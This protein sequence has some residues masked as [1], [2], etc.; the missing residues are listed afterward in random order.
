MAQAPR[1]E[2]QKSTCEVHPEAV[3]Q[4]TLVPWAKREVA[5]VHLWD[6]MGILWGFHGNL[7][8]LN[9][10]RDFMGILFGDLGFNGELH[11]GDLA[12]ISLHVGNPQ[13]PSLGVGWLDDFRPG[14]FH[15]PSCDAANRETKEVVICCTRL[16]HH[17]SNLSPG[18]CDFS[19]QI[20]SDYLLAPTSTSYRSSWWMSN[21]DP[22]WHPEILVPR[23]AKVQKTTATQ[24]EF[25]E[26]AED[27]FVLQKMGVCPM[28]TTQ[29]H[30]FF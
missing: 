1:C 24:R 3:P 20:S 18:F 7:L 29:S 22:K 2:D 9:G 19:D 15:D 30:V 27:E 4:H 10:T 25:I 28:K 5:R 26:L 8:G 13:T 16:V 23:H 14:Q 21:D 6:F 11:I 17:L 12:S